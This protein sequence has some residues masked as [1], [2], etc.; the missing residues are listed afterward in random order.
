M[1]DTWA[2]LLIYVIILGSLGR[3][4]QYVRYYKSHLNLYI[5]C[6]GFVMAA[7]VFLFF[8]AVLKIPVSTI[9]AIMGTQP[10]LIA[11]LAGIFMKKMERITWVTVASAILVSIGVILMGY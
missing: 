3:F 11:I 10:V 9:S 5:I 7:A 2:A 4:K 6:A 8:N 1:L